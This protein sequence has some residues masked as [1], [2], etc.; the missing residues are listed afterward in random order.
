MFIKLPFSDNKNPGLSEYKVADS[1]INVEYSAPK[2]L[3]PKAERK[4]PFEVSK[5]KRG[6]PGRNYKLEV[7]YPKNF[8]IEEKV[9]GFH[10]S[11]SDR[12]V[13]GEYD[14]ND[15]ELKLKKKTG[16]SINKSERKDPFEV[17]KE[18]K[19]DPGYIDTKK[20]RFNSSYNGWPDV[21][22]YDINDAEL[23]LKKKTM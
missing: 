11:K 17:N 22:E 8:Y 14:I 12:P 2:Y 10:T 1:E 6:I 3:I 21:G 16:I 23:K 19:N 15:A 20:P 4:N 5:E 13:V 9:E 7:K 18:K